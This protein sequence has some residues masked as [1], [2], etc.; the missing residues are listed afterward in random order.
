MLLERHDLNGDLKIN[1]MELIGLVQEINGTTWGEDFAN[2]WLRAADNRYYNRR[3]ARRTNAACTYTA[4]E[5]EQGCDNLLDFAELAELLPGF[6]TTQARCVRKTSEDLFGNPKD[7]YMCVPWGHC[8][9]F[10]DPSKPAASGAT[11]EYKCGFGM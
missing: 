7:E 3:N 2:S 1:F 8:G 4:E 6:F 11:V 9:V 10:A 5:L